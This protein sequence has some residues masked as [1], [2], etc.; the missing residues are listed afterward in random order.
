[1]VIFSSDSTWLYLGN[2]ILNLYFQIKRH[3]TFEM[4]ATNVKVLWEFY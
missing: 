3:V 4:T 1:M 2:M